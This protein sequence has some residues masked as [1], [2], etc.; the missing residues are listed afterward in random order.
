MIVRGILFRHAA[1]AAVVASCLSIGGAV[2]E[3]QQPPP[4]GAAPAPAA[5]SP[6]SPQRR[7]DP[8]DVLLGIWTWLPNCT[9]S[10]MT[11]DRNTLAFYDM[12]HQS[13][14][15]DI[16]D[17][18]WVGDGTVAAIVRLHFGAGTPSGPTPQPGSGGV[19]RREG[20]TLRH[21]AWVVN[22]R[23]RQFEAG[24]NGHVMHLCMHPSTR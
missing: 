6:P 19:F 13:Y 16:V 1:A 14:S 18:E 11:F 12:E 8:S 15:S 24:F 21:V 4:K 3:A 22:G 23:V 20:N 9:G 2:S 7:G 5:P 10:P 17:Y